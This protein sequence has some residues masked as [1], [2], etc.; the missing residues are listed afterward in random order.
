MYPDQPLDVALICRS[1]K[2]T[3][4]WNVN[5]Y[6]LQVSIR[7]IPDKMSQCILRAVVED[8]DIIV[9]RLSKELGVN[10]YLHH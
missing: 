4:V 10:R 6:H 5:T 9:A 8:Q 3:N 7:G 1:L 2:I